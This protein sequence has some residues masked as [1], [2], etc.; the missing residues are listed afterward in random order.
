[1]SE[2]WRTI[3]VRHGLND[4]LRVCE[5]LYL[6]LFLSLCECLVVCLCVSLSSV[7]LLYLHRSVLDHV[8]YSTAMHGGKLEAD[9]CL[10]FEADL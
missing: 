1:M 7:L 6:Y 2:S 5:C 9:L 4:C 10:Y 8:T 3:L